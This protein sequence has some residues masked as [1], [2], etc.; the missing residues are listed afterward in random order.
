M[1]DAMAYFHRVLQRLETW[2]KG[3]PQVKVSPAMQDL[4]DRMHSPQVREQALQSNPVPFDATSEAMH[5]AARQSVIDAEDAAFT[6]V[7]FRRGRSWGERSLNHPYFG[8]YPFS[9][10]W[11]KVVPEMVRMLAVNPFGLPI[12]GMLE[13]S[14]PGLGFL[15][16]QR[17][18]SAVEM[19]KDSDPEFREFMTDPR[20]DKMFRA[21]AMFLPATPWDAPAN[22]PLWSRRL[23]EWG[24]ESQQ[25]EEEGRQPK[26]FDLFKTAS[27]VT[28]Y[29]FGPS[30]TL[31]WLSDIAR[32]PEAPAITQFTEGT[33][34]SGTGM[35]GLGASDL[36]L[37]PT[38]AV[39]LGETLQQSSAQLQQNLSP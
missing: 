2:L 37:G 15:N 21:A 38:G 16:A 20:N 26:G 1:R 7:Q 11:G 27:D 34:S 29:A 22:F 17:T 32:I 4:F 31:D 6:N 9:Y 33:E 39:P 28:S 25:R 3:N 8:L 14:T 24:L 18:W 12:P 30:A 13:G 10:M 19:Q 5:Q 36:V 23:A 35:E